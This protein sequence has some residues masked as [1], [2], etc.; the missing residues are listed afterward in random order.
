[1]SPATNPNNSAP[2][3]EEVP[4]EFDQATDVAYK[5]ASDG[6][7]VLITSRKHI[8][9]FESF[10]YWKKRLPMNEMDGWKFASR[11]LDHITK[12]GGAFLRDGDDKYH[13]LVEGRRIPLD[14]ESMPLAD[15]MMEVC[16]ISTQTPIGK[17]AIQRLQREAWKSSSKMTFRRFSA[18]YDGPE[19]R[20]YIPTTEDERILKIDGSGCNLVPNGDN[21]EAVWLEHPA[22][23][24]LQWTGTPSLDQARAAL[25]RFE[26]LLVNTQ[27]C[28]SGPM[29]WLVGMQEGLFPFVR[30]VIANRFL[31]VHNGPSGSGK[32]S[33]AQRFTIL[34]GLGDVL[35]DASIAA[36][37]N[38][39]EQGLIVLDNKEQQNFSQSL[40]DYCLFLATGAARLRSTQDGV[41][42]RAAP[43]PVGVIT[44]IE[45][46]V[47]EE[48]HKR[49]VDIDYAV[50][51]EFIG[52][53]EIES[54]I[55]RE[56]HTIL[57]ALALVLQE[58]L[59]VR[60]DP[61]VHIGVNPIPRF[62]EHFTELAR[63][64]VAFGRV[65]GREDGWAM[66]IIHGWND[67]LKD[68]GESDAAN[69]LEV[70]ILQVID[71]LKGVAKHERW[72]YENRTGTLW[73]TDAG[74]LLSALQQLRIPGLSLPVEPRG[75][76]K[77]LRSDRF[78]RFAVLGDGDSD[79]EELRR[80]KEGRRIGFFVA[81][82]PENGG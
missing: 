79:A 55:R 53:R 34:H 26:E 3:T 66:G 12:R 32:T 30:D 75:F 36:L 33:G 56:R 28:V 1:M 73:V 63:L 24:P 15:L 6:R 16:H 52:R 40:I 59:V 22:D 7:E 2:A 20:I 4:F 61:E 13:I 19:P 74:T 77:R 45:G 29:R 39:P 47:R 76:G 5:E 41:I 43:R 69:P 71:L 46:V 8:K 80:T 81:G 27:A 65:M 17:I 21:P 82:E 35:G 18:M 42:R 70:P 67:V 60:V 58:Y 48:L 38:M 23:D 14:N 31:V 9:Q 25:T 51:G 78:Q 10:M 57:S 54:A 68:R 49:C 72:V 11:L 62:E 44:S 50:S 37:G 64:L